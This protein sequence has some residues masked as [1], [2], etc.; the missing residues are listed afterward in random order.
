MRAVTSKFLS[1]SIHYQ[2]VPAF[3]L[4]LAL[5]RVLNEPQILGQSHQFRFIFGDAFHNLFECGVDVLSR[6][7]RFTT[8]I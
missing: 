7:Q 6:H 1:L 3:Q 2:N 4:M 8:I 5:G